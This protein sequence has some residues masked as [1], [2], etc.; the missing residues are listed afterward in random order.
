[1][2]SLSNYYTQEVR[3]WQRNKPNKLVELQDV[4]QIFVKPMQGQPHSQMQ[5]MIL[6]QQVFS[7]VIIPNLQT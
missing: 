6:S 3:N 1:M 7:H 4:G 2:Y 5:K